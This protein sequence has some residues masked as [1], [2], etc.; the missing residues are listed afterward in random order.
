MDITEAPFL[1][2]SHISRK[3]VFLDLR[4]NDSSGGSVPTFSLPGMDC[5]G[6]NERMG[7]ISSPQP[8]RAGT[9]EH[10]SN[11]LPFCTRVNP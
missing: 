7:Q 1:L 8:G 11:S 4:L 10:V 5:I 3:T 9:I 6:R 2:R